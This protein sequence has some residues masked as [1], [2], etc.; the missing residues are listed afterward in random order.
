MSTAVVKAYSLA[1]SFIR[2]PKSDP[3]TFLDPVTSTN[4]ALSPDG[5]DADA[6][7]W[8]HS[9]PILMKGRGNITIKLHL[10]SRSRLAASAKSI[11]PCSSAMMGT[12]GSTRQFA[13]QLRGFR[14]IRTKITEIMSHG[15]Q[16]QKHRSRSGS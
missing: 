12:H 10:G 7:N 2:S 6:A 15:A 9:L 13:R 3:I 1:L 14:A 8:W 11:I 5:D 4:I 16:R